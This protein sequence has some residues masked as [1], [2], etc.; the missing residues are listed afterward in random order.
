MLQKFKPRIYQ[1]LSLQLVLLVLLF[2][3]MPGFALAAP[4]NIG[5]GV[6]FESFST[7]I[8]G[9]SETM[10]VLE[11]D[12]ANPYLA[13]R[14][15]SPKDQ[16]QN[17]ETVSA[18]AK[19][20]SQPGNWVIGAINGDFFNISGNYRGV[21]SGLHIK[22][23]ELL[24]APGYDAVFGLD[25]AKQP[26]IEYIT[27]GGSVTV[28]GSD[29]RN[30][31]NAV[32]KSRFDNN[33]VLYTPSFGSTTRTNVY[34]TEVVL[35]GLSLPFRPNTYYNAT[36]SEVREAT[37]NTTIPRDGVVLS[38]H[39]T[40]A[41]YLNLLSPGAQVVFSVDLS[42]TGISQA[43]GGLPKVVID[44]NIAPSSELSKTKNAFQSHPRTAVGLRGDKLFWVTVDGR[45]P[46][47]SEGVTLEELGQIMLNLGAEQALNLDGGGSTAMVIRQP[48]DFTHSLANKPAEGRERVVSNSLQLINTAPL[49]SLINLFIAPIA[50]S[51]L[52]I[53]TQ[54]QF[55]VKGL[56]EYYN[57][58]DLLGRV[59]WSINGDIGTIDQEGNFLAANPGSGEIIAAV[60]GVTTKI[61]FTVTEKVYQPTF[62]DVT[63]PGPFDWAKKEIEELAAKKIIYGREANKYGPQDSV[64]R[65][66]F[67]ALL[68]RALKLEK[69]T[70]P[71]TT[72][73]DVYDKSD[74]YAADIEVAVKEGL[75]NG[76]SKTSFG[77]NNSISRVE[78][79]LILGR[80][81]QTT[82]P[83]QALPVSSIDPLPK[84]ADYLTIP[85]WALQDP[86]LKLAVT[87]GLIQGL[88]A[89]NGQIY[90]TPQEKGNRAQAAVLIKRFYDKTNPVQILN[91]R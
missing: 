80:A 90:L 49:G 21:P 58:I 46:G 40:G 39:G 51:S 56:D 28:Q 84:F 47:Y 54:Q 53:G 57:P 77:P 20:Q 83:N 74:W 62:I 15:S 44:G 12:S 65:A 68:V 29:Y 18:Q 31:I 14:A 1:A 50:E 13:F 88:P 32:N 67:T 76:Y 86:S 81:L 23:G 60:E 26:F 61:P 24:S 38:G 89:K 87:Q 59:N 34:G 48:G 63:D 35:T 17:L 79:A 72:F 66:E 55:Q 36:V 43:I 19:R 85:D 82:K 10:Q 30:R 5:P 2:Q 11:I 64:T 4:V 22:D 8:N 41:M 73:Q 52:E 6:T 25:E 9:N 70:A 33:L 42:K 7:Q 71:K 27:M 78:M 69:S 3:V 37:G 16:V 45:Q 91:Y 75:I